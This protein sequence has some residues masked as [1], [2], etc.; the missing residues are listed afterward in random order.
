MSLAQSFNQT[1]FDQA[2]IVGTARLIAAKIRTRCTPERIFLFGSAATGHFKVGSDFDFL[3]VFSDLEKMR[4]ARQ[5][6]RKDGKLHKD[7][8]VDLVFMTSEEFAARQ[9]AGGLCYVVTKE[10]LEL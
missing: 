7:V 5:A 4:A 3:L 1:P 2:Q 6:I 8:P 10:G 9:A